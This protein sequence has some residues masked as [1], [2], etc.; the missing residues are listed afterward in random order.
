MIKYSRWLLAIFIMLL[1]CNPVFAGTLSTSMGVSATVTPACTALSAT[2]LSFG[3]VAAANLNK[4]AAS[5]ITVT[6]VASVPFN[7]T[8]SDGLH[9]NYF[10][11]PVQRRMSAGPS[12]FCALCV[13]YE[14]YVDAGRTLKWHDGNFFSARLNSVGNGSAQTFPVYGRVSPGPNTPPGQY[15]DTVVVNLN[16]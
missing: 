15:T 9:A 7:V 1:G 12:L 3:T 14:L 8:I 16:F 11:I 13:N 4:D 5:T 6:C 2:N 10:S